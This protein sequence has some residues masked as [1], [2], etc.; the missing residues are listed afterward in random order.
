MAARN[1]PQNTRCDMI[2]TIASAIEV[3][4]A[5]ECEVMR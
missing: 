4:I 3:Q 2:P 1:F 5:M